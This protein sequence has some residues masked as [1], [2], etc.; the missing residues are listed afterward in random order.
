[1][2][3]AKIE[4]KDKQDE[5]VIETPN[6]FTQNQLPDNAKINIRLRGIMVE[7]MCMLAPEIY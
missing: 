2:K 3:A 1:M 7:I 4:A 5:A 6:A